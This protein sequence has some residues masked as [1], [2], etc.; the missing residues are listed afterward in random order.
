MLL[1]LMGVPFI[2]APCEAE[3]QCAELAKKVNWLIGYFQHKAN[4]IVVIL[5]FHNRAKYMP[6]QLKIWMH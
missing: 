4:L 3:A 6:R 1:G 5:F 2:V